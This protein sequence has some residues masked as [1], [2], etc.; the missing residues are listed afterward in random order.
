[1]PFTNPAVLIL[2]AGHL[3]STPLA[4]RHLVPEGLILAA[5]NLAL[6]D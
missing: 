2:M 6:V 1:M 5:L 4:L 3:I